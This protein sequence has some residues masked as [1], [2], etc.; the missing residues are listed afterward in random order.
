MSDN[1]KSAEKFNRSVLSA[2][3][4]HTLEKAV[5]SKPCDKNIKKTVITFFGDG[6]GLKA[7]SETFMRDGKCIQKILTPDDALDFITSKAPDIYRQTDVFA[8]NKTISLLISSKGVPHTTGSLEG[9]KT[10]VYEDSPDKKKN[11]I[12]TPE[13]GSDF[14]F[15]LGIT[16]RTGRIHDKKQAKY[17]QINKFLEQIEAVC[18]PLMQKDSI[19]MLDLC[20]G[21]SYLTFAAHWYFQTVLKKK[22]VTVGVDLKPDVIETC[23]GI[24]RKL[25]MEGLSFVCMNVSEY[26]PEFHPDI[27]ISLHACDIATDYVL[28]SAVNLGAEIILSTPCCQHQLGRDMKPGNLDFISRYPILKQ[29]FASVATDALR[30]LILE[31][32]G[33]SVTV[34]EFTDPEETP[35][36]IMIRAVKNRSARPV[37]D[38]MQML[39]EAETLLGAEP[40]LRT[41]LPVPDAKPLVL[42]N[43]PTERNKK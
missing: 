10:A 11:Y 33:Y 6:E 7:K 22:T 41:L 42:P 4:L 17:R 19:F 37:A 30:A 23:T 24:S 18:P 21:K 35:K 27:V 3:R 25:G 9:A 16:D 26:K 31:I 12:L 13:N 8:G 15:A 36:N 5:M 34:C 40:F 14:L 28:S 32:N 38:K 1:G 20:C 2:F 43:Y 29:K 39:K